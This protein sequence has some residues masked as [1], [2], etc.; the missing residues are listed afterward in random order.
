M[1]GK[2]D[3]LDYIEAGLS[4]GLLPSEIAEGYRGQLPRDTVEELAL[5]AIRI[6]AKKPKYAGLIEQMY[7]SLGL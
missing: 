6:M 3:S 4:K 1:S 5:G 7:G 2:S